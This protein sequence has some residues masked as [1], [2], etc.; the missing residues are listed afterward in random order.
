MTLS[1][2]FTFQKLNCLISKSSSIPK[3]I[4]PKFTQLNNSNTEKIEIKKNEVKKS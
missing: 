4:G 2:K 3:K 1:E